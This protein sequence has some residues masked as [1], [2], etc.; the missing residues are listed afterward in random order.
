MN[1]ILNINRA[2]RLIAFDFRRILRNYGLSA[3]VISLLPFICTFIYGFLAMVFGEGWAH[4]G[5]GSRALMAFVFVAMMV[6]SLPVS[7]YGFITDRRA[8]SSYLM[9]P[10]STVEKFISIILN[11][12]VIFPVLMCAVFLLSDSLLVVTGL[13]GGDYLFSGIS[14]W[15]AFG[16]TDFGSE[17]SSI[18]ITGGC[19]SLVNNLLFFLLGG[20]FFKRTKVVKTILVILGLQILSTTFIAPFAN[21]IDESVSLSAFWAD[22]RVWFWVINI[23]EILVLDI[24]IYLRVKT[25]KH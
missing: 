13:A 12:V 17:L 7:A 10:A 1:D 23:V 4:P 22:A 16:V 14:D 24:L 15:D 2:S 5:I 18:L 3:L 8:G 6:L 25:L 21:A 20:L 9:I 19:F 11:A